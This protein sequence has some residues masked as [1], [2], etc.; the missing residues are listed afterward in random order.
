VATARAITLEA[1]D[2]AIA[3]EGVSTGDGGRVSMSPFA[4]KTVLDERVPLNGI[5]QGIIR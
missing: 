1:G 4:C 3:I 5:G 2:I